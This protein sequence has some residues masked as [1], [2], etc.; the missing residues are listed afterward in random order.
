M[1]KGKEAAIQAKVDKYGKLGVSKQAIG[2]LMLKEAS[3]KGSIS[4]GA[5]P[6]GFRTPIVRD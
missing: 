1:L 5:S 6:G 3:T 2:A 4:P